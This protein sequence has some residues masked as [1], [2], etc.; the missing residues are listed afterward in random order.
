MCDM[1]RELTREEIEEE[2]EPGLRSG[3][4]NNAEDTA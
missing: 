2:K 3:A 4:D 1:L